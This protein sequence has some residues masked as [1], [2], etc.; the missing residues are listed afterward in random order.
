MKLP[1]KTP[2]GT[3]SEAGSVKSAAPP[4]AAKKLPLP[5][6]AVG[7]PPA[8]KLPLKAPGGKLPLKLPLKTPSGT[9]SGAASDA[10][11]SDVGEADPMAGAAR[12][13]PNATPM[14]T[15][16]D[17]PS[18]ATAGDPSMSTYA[19][20]LPSARGDL[21]AAAL[22]PGSTPGPPLGSP[23][24]SVPGS[25]VPSTLA[26]PRENLADILGP[27]GASGMPIPPGGLPGVAPPPSLVG[28]NPQQQANAA[29]I[30][31]GNPAAMQQVLA[32]LAAASASSAGIGAPPHDTDL[33]RSVMS[34]EWP[35]SASP[36]GRMAGYGGGGGPSLSQQKVD[37]YEAEIRQLER[38][39]LES[40]R[41]ANDLQH[42][43]SRLRET[44]YEREGVKVVQHISELER[45]NRKLRTLLQKEKDAV[46]Y[47]QSA[48]M[49]TM[50]ELVR[51]KQNVDASGDYTKLKADYDK[52]QD[53]LSA[54]VRANTE[55]S[56]KL[57][58]INELY[59]LTTV[60]PESYHALRKSGGA[61]SPARGRGLLESLVMSEPA[62]PFQDRALDRVLPTFV[63]VRRA[64][65]CETC[66]LMVD[67]W[68]TVMSRRAA[69]QH[70]S[71]APSAAHNDPSMEL[72]MLTINPA[73]GRPASDVAAGWRALPL[74]SG[75]VVYHNPV[76]NR[77]QWEMP[78]AVRQLSQLT[79]ATVAMASSGGAAGGRI[80][81]FAAPRT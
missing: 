12:P 69:A 49:S 50:D 63:K 8:G 76:T 59:T 71:V 56:M 5:G 42:E 10:A 39:L 44:L 48:H 40:E 20:P 25:L 6:K 31:T 18:A 57:A 41:H 64:A 35:A 15:P 30:M 74:P 75:G 68:E 53:Q 16:R 54:T 47:H 80:G 19:T 26:S 66:Q 70:L 78:E 51:F 37:E 29:A 46:L 33:L 45:E 52:L 4:L 22:S 81:G 21:A 14:P 27:A 72:N 65:L 32:S 1:L 77:S 7:T 36:S 55:L 9:P 3:P 60:A 62:S 58:E 38:K 11:A 13:D 24:A 17:M 67:R 2:S 61:G 23:P 34:G 79:G 73:T 43:S 28:L